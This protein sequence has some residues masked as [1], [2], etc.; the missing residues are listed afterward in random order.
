[1]EV[2]PIPA[3]GL[4][5]RAGLLVGNRAAAADSVELIEK[6]ILLHRARRRVD[7]AVR[8]ALLG[9]RGSRHGDDQRERHGTDDETDAADQH[10]HD[11][12]L[13]SWPPSSATPRTADEPI[14][15]HS[16]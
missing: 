9:A 8:V 2:A 11:V 15:W 16:P 5:D 12:F 1:M 10:R 7:Q 14:S 4:L 13:L 6:L 3:G